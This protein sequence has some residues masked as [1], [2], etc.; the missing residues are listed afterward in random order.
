M[1]EVGEERLESDEELVAGGGVELGEEK[2]VGDV[3]GGR[4]A[5]ESVDVEVV[6][7]PFGGDGDGESRAAAGGLVGKKL[8]DGEGAVV[9]EDLEPVVGAAVAMAESDAERGGGSARD[10]V[11]EERLEWALSHEETREVE[12]SVGLEDRGEDVLGEADAW[13][14]VGAVVGVA[15]EVGAAEGG[16]ERGDEGKLLSVGLLRRGLG[17]AWVAGTGAEVVAAAYGVADE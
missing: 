4:V 11:G 1:G 10:R 7:V 8:R 12:G 6:G 5:V 15:E 9:D 3:S 16:D 2:G 13:G 14:A 17:V